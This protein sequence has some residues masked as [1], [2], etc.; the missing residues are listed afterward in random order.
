M[1][2]DK[3]QNISNQFG[4]HIDIKEF[5]E[6]T[7]TSADAAKSIG[8]EISQIAKSILFKGEKQENLFL[9]LQAVLTE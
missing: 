2:I 3:I 8:C 4:F 5:P 7:K 9:L 6:S 1:G